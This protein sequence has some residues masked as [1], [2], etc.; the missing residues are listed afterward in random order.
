MPFKSDAHESIYLWAAAYTTSPLLSV[1]SSSRIFQ[2]IRALHIAGCHVHAVVSSF[3]IHQ[4]LY[5]HC[6]GFV[7][8]PHDDCPLPMGEELSHPEHPQ[9]P[10]DTH[11][12]GIQQVVITSILAADLTL[13]LRRIPAGFYVTVEANG[14]TW[15]TSNKPVHVDQVVIEWN[16]NI[17]LP[18]EP[19]SK[20]RVAVYASF[21]LSPMLGHG[22]RLRR[23]EVSVG[24]LV[25]RS[26]NSRRP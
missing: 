1:D 14:T 17:L 26:E 13:G 8:D 6:S 15:Q 19:S 18:S 20:V 11:V 4:A 7:P 10:G 21:E 23:F 2:Y 16:E 5:G 12:S 24:E 9:D 3:I 25:E 22:E